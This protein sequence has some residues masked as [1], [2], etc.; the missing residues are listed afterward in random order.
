MLILATANIKMR[1][2]WFSLYERT[3]M[4]N[5][6]S[7]DKIIPASLAN[8]LINNFSIMYKYKQDLAMAYFDDHSKESASK[9]FANEIHSNKPHLAALQAT[10]YS[11]PRKIL[12]PKQIQII[13]SFLG[14][15]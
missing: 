9:L 13:F 11:R 4:F 12:S 10:G 3:S 1:L 5:L 15:P 7:L 2:S 14:E 8:C 6:K